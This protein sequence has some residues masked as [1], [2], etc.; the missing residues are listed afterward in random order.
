[1]RVKNDKVTSDTWVG[2]EIAA[3]G[4]YDISPSEL[5]KWQSDNKV[6]ADLSSEDLI[7]GDGTTWKSGAAEAV[8][9]L[10]GADTEPRDSAGRK[11]T[12]GAVTEDG[13]HFDPEWIELTTSTVD[14]FYNK[15]VDGSDLGQCEV[16]LY[17]A[18]GD[19]ITT[20]SIADLYC[21]KTVLTFTPT[22]DHQPIGASIFQINAPA[23][24][25]RV[26]PR[27]YPGTGNVIFG[28]GGIN[29][30][31]A[32]LYQAVKLD[33][34]AVKNMPYYPG[35]KTWEFT[36]LHNAGVKHALAFFMEIFNA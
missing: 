28:N 18:N 14:G 36:L 17:K 32:G 13:W 21:V 2:Q 25:V 30:K 23:T 31:F 35:V 20:Q 5:F 1:M 8:N 26:Y 16:K 3:A 24:D 15:G 22:H 6:I 11:I 27:A 33:G 19:L 29:L 4:E 10:L 34:R 7:I 9:F 12:R